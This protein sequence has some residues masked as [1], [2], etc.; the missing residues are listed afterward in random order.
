MYTDSQPSG[1]PTEVELSKCRILLL[2]GYA[3]TVYAHLGY[4]KFTIMHVLM[5]VKDWLLTP[6]LYHEKSVKQ[7]CS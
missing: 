5:T 6:L 3:K 7:F 2:K 1:T 4:T